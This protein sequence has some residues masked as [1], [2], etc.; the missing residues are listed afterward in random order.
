MKKL[1][2]IDGHSLAFRAFFALPITMRTTSGLYTN[3]AF[4]FTN[5]LQKIFKDIDPD[6]IIVAFDK[7]KVTFR[8]EI[9]A[10]YKGTRSSMPEELREQVCYIE[11]IL[12]AYNI[13][14]IAIEG[15]EAD[16]IIGTIARTAEETGDIETIIITGDRDAYQLVD[17]HT[18]VYYT[19]K[20]L[21][22]ILQMN[23]EAIAE[24]YG[25]SPK[26]LI[27]VKA[28]MG[29]KSDNIPGVPGVGEK[30]AVKLIKE[31]QDLD[32]VYRNIDKIK[33]KVL[34]QRIIN[35]KDAAYLSYRLAKI[36]CHMSID[37]SWKEV[38]KQPNNQ[39]L[40]EIFSHLEFNK[41]LKDLN[42]QA[43]FEEEA[44]EV[45]T[46]M[47]DTKEAGDSLITDIRADNQLMFYLSNTIE[48][49]Y[50]Y[51]PGPEK[52]VMVDEKIWQTPEWQELL[53]DEKLEKITCHLKDTIHFLN[54]LNIELKGVVFDITLAGYVLDPSLSNYELPLMITKYLA[55]KSKNLKTLNES[56]YHQ[57]IY[58]PELYQEM[59]RNINQQQLNDLYCKVE[60]PLAAV[61]AQ[62][63]DN[64]IAID[65][66][67]LL[68]MASELEAG[69]NNMKNQIYDL[70]GEEFNINS[71]KQLGV[72]LF[73]KLKLP[74][75]K[76]TKTGY[77]TSHEVLET[78]ALEHDLPALIIHYRQLTKLKS[79]YID[80]ILPLITSSS[81]LHTTFKQTITTT[82]RLSSTE[83]NLQNIPI[84]LEE[85]RRIRKAF[86]PGQ[87]YDYLLSADY[88]QIELRILA[89]L[90][91]DP[92]LIK[93]FQSNE[94]IHTRTASEVFGVAPQ[95]V[96]REMR[97]RAKAVNFG[98]IYGISDYGL[99]RDLKV[100]R[101][102][103]GV[104]I[105]NY[106]ARYQLV[107]SYLD[108]A[109]LTA[110]KNGYVETMLNRRRYLPDINSRNF[111][112]RSFAERIATNT[113]IQG[114]AADLI[115]LAM[116]RLQ[117]ELLA[118]KYQSRMLLQVHDEL[119]LEVTQEELQT[120]A[121]LLERTMKN[122]MNL[123]VPIKVDVKFGVNWYEMEELSCLN[124]PK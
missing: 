40:Y 97:F 93:A 112:R 3:A 35:N 118:G 58:L 113:P 64:G 124:C 119:I 45:R 121:A 28:L 70:A 33:G 92:I 110:K 115:K 94:D 48:D 52:L 39:Q 19:R 62:L 57:L 79:T 7:G 109:I 25:L 88:S 51:L 111:H 26:Q 91:S 78:L 36:D 41:L 29:D 69:I 23:M 84:R 66:S 114:S 104:Y 9:Y 82:G 120:V 81:R 123:S 44:E 60:L 47:V 11:D 31:F 17:H 34:P 43:E 37:L 103:A 30:T 117:Q 46:V 16:D 107:R 21:S 50:L 18:T 5:M 14:Q 32:G 86:V 12:T 8:N 56:L 80:G 54:T 13:K 90:S 77:S 83:P 42:D 65:R 106:F 61:L 87:G 63:E 74:V 38:R 100:T 27:D 68:Q 122:A 6:Y 55:D 108:N 53:E 116:V 22:D 20:G 102:E 101:K 4:G 2:L 89:H 67:V 72:I 15:Y 96:T 95:D 71:P 1:V 98:I 49:Q 105:D 10:D 85:G 75:L 76:K 99:A 73:D 59:L 24:K